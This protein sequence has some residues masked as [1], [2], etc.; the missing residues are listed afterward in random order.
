MAAAIS[1][2]LRAPLIARRSKTKWG[3]SGRYSQ[4]IWLLPAGR[5]PS[6]LH[7]SPPA[8]VLT[9][10]GSDTKVIGPAIKVFF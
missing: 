10:K 8:V 9:V 3:P 7:A 1:S 4:L 5:D 2:S 6:M